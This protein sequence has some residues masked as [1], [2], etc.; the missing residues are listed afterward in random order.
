MRKLLGILAI[1]VAVIFSASSGSAET[2]EQFDA[3]LADELN[4]LDPGAIDIWNHANAAR[5]AGQ[6]DLAAGLYADVF[7]RVPMF[8]HALRRE[9]GEE[10]QLGKRELALQHAHD[11]VFIARSAENLGML[12]EALVVIQRGQATAAEIAEARKITTEALA[13]KPKDGYLH[14]VAAQIAIVS[15]DL[16]ALKHETETLERL[17]PKAF[18]TQAYQMFS[19]SGSIETSWV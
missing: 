4:A 17:D 16:D 15:N 13:L 14:S 19:S 10:L 1:A 9:A 8:V 3:K 5:A 12:A 7:K 11:A 2:L 18:Q 6:H